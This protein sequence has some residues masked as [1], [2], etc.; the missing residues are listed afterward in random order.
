MSNGS[1]PYTPLMT[2]VAES[3]ATGLPVLSDEDVKRGHEFYE[4]LA[5]DL[6]QCGPLFRLASDRAN[7]IANWLGDLKRERKI[8]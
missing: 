8:L 7:V 1:K 5:S 4:K 2:R 3:H 6:M